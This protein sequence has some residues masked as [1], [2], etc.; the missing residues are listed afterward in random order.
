VSISVPPFRDGDVL[1]WTDLKFNPLGIYNL[2]CQLGVLA[3]EPGIFTRYQ[4]WF[5]A[6]DIAWFAAG[7]S[8]DGNHHIPDDSFHVAFN[9]MCSQLPAGTVGVSWRKTVCS[10]LQK[11]IF[12]LV[13]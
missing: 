11:L 10:H 3:K 12:D 6:S 9:V 5:E 13:C 7:T 8:E 2:H 1:A 4:H